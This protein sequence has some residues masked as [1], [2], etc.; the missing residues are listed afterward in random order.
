LQAAFI[1]GQNEKVKLF[2]LME[3]SPVYDIKN[4]TVKLAA[5]IVLNFIEGVSRRGN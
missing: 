1:S 5:E 4:K 2:N 3:V